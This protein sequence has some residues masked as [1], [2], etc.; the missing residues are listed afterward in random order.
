MRD[1]TKHFAESLLE[2]KKEEH[3]SWS[4]NKAVFDA[5]YCAVDID[6]YRADHAEL[7]S[8]MM[9]IARILSKDSRKG[10]PDDWLDIAGYAL[11]RYNAISKGEIAEI[12]IY[13]KRPA[14]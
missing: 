8:I 11:L 12:K 4:D 3:G 6:K 1:I 7:I 5:L 10:N 13:Q 9:K 14:D 2:A